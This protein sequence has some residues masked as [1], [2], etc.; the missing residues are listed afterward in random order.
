LTVRRRPFDAGGTGKHLGESSL[1]QRA[2]AGKRFFLLANT[3]Q[4]SNCHKFLH[5]Q[6]KPQ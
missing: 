1:I 3:C 2:F 5:R 4:S 6:R